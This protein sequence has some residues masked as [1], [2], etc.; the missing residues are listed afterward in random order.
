MHANLFSSQA[1]SNTSGFNWAR[2]A[3]AGNSFVNDPGAVV[4]DIV[5]CFLK[6]LRSRTLHKAARDAP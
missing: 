2:I 1:V 5:A 3:I 6:N 4:V